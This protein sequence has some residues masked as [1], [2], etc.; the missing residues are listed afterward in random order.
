[1]PHVRDVVV[2]VDVA[3]RVLVIQ[4]LATATHDVQRVAAIRNA[5]VPADV[6]ASRGRDVG[7][8]HV[9]RQPA[10][11]DAQH[12]VRVGKDA[13]PCVTLAGAHRTIHVA[14][15]VE[16]VGGELHVHVRPPVPVG[17][18]AADASELGALSDVL[19]DVKRVQRVAREVPVEREELQRIRVGRD[20]TQH[21]QRTIVV[22][23]IRI[24]EAVHGPVER[25]VER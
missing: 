11:R 16:H 1:M 7:R 20:M 10:G 17:R 25:C 6:R 24:F 3:M 23:V 18:V 19:A 4:V 21:D 8:G 22:M 12:Q 5:Q 14:G 2:P 9:M 13:V 15:Y